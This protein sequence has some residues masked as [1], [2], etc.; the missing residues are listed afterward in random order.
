M[1]NNSEILLGEKVVYS[2]T[3]GFVKLTKMRLS[4]LVVFSAVITYFTVA[5][6]P[7]WIKFAALALGGFLVTASANTFNQVIERDLDKLMKRTHNRPIPTNTLSPAEALIFAS[8]CGL[9][10]VIVLYLF[11]NPLSGIL[12]FASII[13][14]A[15]AYTPLKRITPFSVFVGAIPG[16]L[17]ILI[18]AIAE[19][20]GFGRITLF[21]VLLFGI[22]FFWQFPHFWAIAWVSHDDYQKAGFFMLPSLGGRDQSSRYQILIYTLFLLPISILPFLFGFTG[23]FS[24]AVILL[25]GIIFYLQAYKLYRDGAIE[26]ARKLM[27]GSF[28]YLPLVQL[29]LM[30]G[31]HGKF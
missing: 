25:C 4:L 23:I 30:I 26:S 17:P 28:L 27:F 3:A 12:S 29:A 22:Q 5:S 8:I 31:S 2:K 16:A 19:E 9:A 21:P 18:G 20:P 13:L 1:E 24:A 11:T 15:L 14:Y 7:D 6:T 10:G